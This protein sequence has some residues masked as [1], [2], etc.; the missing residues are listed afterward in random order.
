MIQHKCANGVVRCG[1]CGTLFTCKI[2]Y[3]YHLNK[4]DTYC[5]ITHEEYIKCDDTAKKN[6]YI[7]SKLE[8]LEITSEINRQA[9][10]KQYETSCMLVDMLKIEQW[11]NIAIQIHGDRYD[12]SKVNLD[13]LLLRIICNI[14]GEFKVS[15]NQHIM[16]D[17]GC[18]RCL[19]CPGCE[20]IYTGGSPCRDCSPYGDC[21][22]CKR[23]Y[24]GK[25]C[26]RCNESYKKT[27][28][29][30]VVTCLR[31]NITGHNFIHNKSIG[32]KYTGKHILPDIRFDKEGY[33]LIVE[34]NEFKHSGAAY[35]CDKQRMY[36]IIAK[37]GTPCIFIRYNPDHKDSD[38]SMLIK[39]V[40]NYLE[41][42]V[43]DLKS[44]CDKYGM[45]CDYMYY[46]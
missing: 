22:I 27:K 11:K 21:P 45:K 1:S 37:L 34:V 32:R 46:D 23:F 7:L 36:D 39:R 38:I 19:F 35:S 44:V 13:D 18:R 20:K 17:K 3:E 12:Y 31:K 2:D 41:I 24:T 40:R 28:E 25:S 10:I 6:I 9:I 30:K 8:Q 43:L 5:G 15:S 42:T 33:N 14:H 29:W 26:P 4:N 16:N